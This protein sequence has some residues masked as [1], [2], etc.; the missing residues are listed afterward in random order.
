MPITLADLALR[1]LAAAVAVAEDLHFGRAA[2]RLGL[3]QPTLSQRVQRVEEALGTPLYE[4]TARRV[5]L[6]P[7]GRRLLPMLRDLL[8]R[9][10]SL[11]DSVA[12]DA[13][14][15]EPI[16]L[17]VIP[18]LGPAIVPH[19][20]LG[21]PDE[22]PLPLHTFREH[23]TAELLTLLRSGELDAALLSLPVASDQLLMLP[24]FDEPFRLVVRKGH[25]LASSPRLVPAQLLAHEMVLLGEG[26]CLRDQA[27]A[28]CRS[29][30]P[31]SPRVIAAGLDVLK[32][33]VAAGEGYSLLPLTACRLTPPLDD[34]LEIRPFDEREPMRRIAIGARA[35]SP[36]VTELRSL[37][38]GIA[39]RLLAAFGP[40]GL[41]P[42]PPSQ[43]RTGS[44]PDR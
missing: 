13:A 38:R 32:Y 17:G 16:R 11:S 25:P 24:I 40:L 39:R 3:P 4:R 22:P 26:H 43:R 6:T 27:L 21:H 41:R 34:L 29:K 28:V 8:A 12:A 20:L 44:K 14:T 7:V 23:T 10:A 9:A 2:A 33:L 36:R 18:T 1:D 15:A 37:A 42:V 30:G 31:A 35:S 5:L 19:L